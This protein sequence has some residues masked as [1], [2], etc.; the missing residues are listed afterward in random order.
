M[1]PKTSQNPW[2]IAII[3]YFAIFITF[4]VTFIVWATRQRVD[5]VRADY[6]EA[7][8]KFQQQIDRV[9]RSRPVEAQLTINYDEKTSKITLQLPRD[10]QKDAYGQIELYRPS[11][12]RQDKT[13]KL[14]VN[15]NGL[16]QLNVKT[17][18]TGLWKLRV[19]WT[20]SGHEYFIE[21]PITITN[22]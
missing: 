8:I 5:L 4:I 6:Y 14:A 17:L 7:E 18:Q 21:K 12:A 15:E 16:Q 13:M 10:S 1:N 19:T 9:E 22:S 20:S 2:P 11:D 3:T